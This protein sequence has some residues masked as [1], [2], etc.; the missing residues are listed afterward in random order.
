MGSSY[1]LFFF[2]KQK[3]AYEMRI[4]DWSSDVCSSDLLASDSRFGRVQ[5]RLRLR[6]EVDGLVSAWTRSMPRDM[7][8]ERC[9]PAAV[10]IGPINSIHEIFH[11]PQYAARE[12]LLPTFYPD[13]DAHTLPGDVPTLLAVP[14]RHA[15]AG[16]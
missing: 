7:V 4:S 16:P 12:N 9:L 8:M 2:F 13:V 6:D 1:V 11:D 15:T 5:E 14:R 10:P 3:T